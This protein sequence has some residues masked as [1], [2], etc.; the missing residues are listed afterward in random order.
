MRG[1]AREGKRKRQ[2]ER[3]RE[4]DE[5]RMLEEGRLER[6]P[7][8]CRRGEEGRGEEAFERQRATYGG[9]RWRTVGKGR[10]VSNLW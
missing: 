2:R 8:G 6:R 10:A 7:M 3:E 4:T 9:I 1:G 5:R